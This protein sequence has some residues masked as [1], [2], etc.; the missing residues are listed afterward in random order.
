MEKF[1]K[2]K[3][4][5]EIQS[6]KE[7]EMA[8]DGKYIK[9]KVDD[10]WEYTIES[11]CVVCLV[12]IKDE[13]YVIMRSEPVP[14]WSYNQRNNTQ[15]L[16]GLFLTLI[17]GTIEDGETPQ[18]C[19]RRELYEEAGIVMSEFKQLVIDD[20]VYRSKGSTGKYY[21]CLLEL[22]YN[23]YKLVAAPGDGSKSEKM[24]KTIKISVADLDNIKVN[25]MISKYLIDK[26]KNEY[27]L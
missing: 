20:P 5:Q 27:N 19:L 18:G 6:Q 11:D 14:P 3:K 9:V 2:I 21:T 12:Y 7:N 10:D 16:S 13:G 24:S 25:D 1:T 22:N 26:M 23:D 15:K 4:T 17:S 8:Y